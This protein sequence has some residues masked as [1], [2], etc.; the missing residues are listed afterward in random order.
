[1]RARSFGGQMAPPSRVAGLLACCLGTALLTACGT[2]VPPTPSQLASS[3]DHALAASDS[4]GDSAT[5]GDSSPAAGESVPTSDAAVSPSGSRGPAATALTPSTSTRPTTVTR[6]STARRQTGGA[7]KASIPTSGRGWD[8]KE[9]HIGIN[10]QNDSSTAGG[11]LGL[12]ISLGDPAG[13]ARAIADAINRSGGVFG[14]KLVIDALDNASGATLADPASAAAQNCA[15]F[16]QDHPVV[17]M[18]SVSDAIETDGFR[19]CMIKART[20]I[21]SISSIGVDD[22]EAAALSP[23]FYAV[24]VANYSVAARL[25][26]GR[27]KVQG[28]FN[29]WSATTGSPG[30]AKAKVGILNP[31]TPFGRRAS[32]ALKGAVEAEGYSTE[33][34]E[35]TAATVPSD[36]S[37]AVLRFASNGVTHVIAVNTY[38]LFF[39]PSAQSQGYHPRYGVTSY[40]V[41][42]VTQANVPRSEFR[43]AMGIGWN[44]FTDVDTAHDPGNVQPAKAECLAQLRAGGQTF[45]ESDKDRLA[46]TVALATCDAVRLIAQATKAASG[47][48]PSALKQG[49]ASVGPSF[50][51]GGTFASGL[52]A[53]QLTMPGVARD[54]VFDDACTCF[55]YRGESYPIR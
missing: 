10:S 5:T 19:A 15:Y 42:S 8:A 33:T 32:A 37:A 36:S 28:W 29:G 12:S 13:D 46:L 30:P 55:T 52:S 51:T 22:V 1:M 35:H 24:T 34:F 3:P 38:L 20:P 26:V 18:I 41:P 47:L 4:T 49:V 31:A 2:T 16:T 44:P 6:P 25:L 23:F 53:T 50:R 39:I 21:V 7:V 14:R 40:N 43:G 27:L 11:A 17:A 48:D 54:N 45:T 9:I